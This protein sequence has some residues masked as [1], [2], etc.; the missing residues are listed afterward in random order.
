MPY[1]YFNIMN[2]RFAP[3]PSG[4]MHI[5]NAS[6][7]LLSWLQIKNIGGKI[8]LRIEDIDPERSKKNYV[9]S[10]VE[11]LNALGLFWD[12]VV[13]F[14]S[15]RSSAYKLALDYLIRQNLIFACSCSKKEIRQTLWSKNA[16]V[17][18]YTGTCLNKGLS[19]DGPFTLRLKSWSSYPILRR[20]DKA[21]AY[22]FSTV[23]DDEYQN[24]THIVRGLD[25]KECAP[26]QNHFRSLL[27]YNSPRIYYAPIW[28]GPD[29]NKI[30]KRHGDI[31]I[32]DLLRKGWSPK[33]IIGLIAARLNLNSDSDACSPDALIDNYASYNWDKK[34]VS[35][36]E[37]LS[38]WL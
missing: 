34:V 6:T 18:S 23:I 12:G 33:S 27:E 7:A 11:D 31:S 14:Q 17:N 26:L 25:L 29:K 1:L 9:N 5:G 2:G 8:Y 35:S 28:C 13:L 37:V 20:Y 36:N 30:S 21:W 24:I 22:N 10:I 38:L 19:L 32:K 3:S 15:K 4:H 16:S